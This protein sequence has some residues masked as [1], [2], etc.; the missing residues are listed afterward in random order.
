MAEEG[1]SAGSNSSMG[2]G[3]AAHP[4]SDAIWSRALKDRRSKVDERGEL[5][6]TPGCRKGRRNL[7]EGGVRV[8]EWR[9]ISFPFCDLCHDRHRWRAPDHPT[10]ARA[11]F[12]SMRVRG[13]SIVQDAG[14]CMGCAQGRAVRMGRRAGGVARLPRSA[15][16]SGGHRIH[17]S[18]MPGGWA[19][20]RSRKAPMEG[21]RQEK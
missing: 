8:S 10:P 16:K 6:V 12:P 4:S 3:G 20:T 13:M 1:A 15:S 11:T 21:G 17:G 2:A 7:P 9:G 19:V 18:A 5:G 14:L